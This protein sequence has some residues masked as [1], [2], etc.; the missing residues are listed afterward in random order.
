[1]TADR[2]QVAARRRDALLLIERARDACRTA[3][4]LVLRARHLVGNS[5]CQRCGVPL[6]ISPGSR[7]DELLCEVCRALLLSPPDR[8][9]AR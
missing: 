2:K 8:R 7:P 5:R 1:V 4:L 3:R 6:I 9:S